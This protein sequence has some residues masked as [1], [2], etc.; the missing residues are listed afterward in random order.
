MVQHPLNSPDTSFEVN[1]RT[2][3]LLMFSTFFWHMS[4]KLNGFIGALH[5]ER[6]LINRHRASESEVAEL[7]FWAETAPR[8]TTRKTNT[9]PP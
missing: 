3:F 5:H 6:Q 9:M 7:L 4:G 8:R 2:R 1:P